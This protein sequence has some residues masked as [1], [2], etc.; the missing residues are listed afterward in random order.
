MTPA[1][2]EMA[3]RSCH[4]LYNEWVDEC[5]SEDEGEEE[6][7]NESYEIWESERTNYDDKTG[8]REEDI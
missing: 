7:E 1:Q 2:E 8:Y 6:G 3:L 5:E 4:P